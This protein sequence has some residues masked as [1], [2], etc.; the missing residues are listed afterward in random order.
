MMLHN[1]VFIFIRVECK[2]K[3]IVWYYGIERSVIVEKNRCFL[4]FMMQKL[5]VSV[6]LNQCAVC[7]IPVNMCTPKVA[8]HSAVFH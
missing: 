2:Y 7:G 6:N 8:V 1:L 3:G 4:D 5:D